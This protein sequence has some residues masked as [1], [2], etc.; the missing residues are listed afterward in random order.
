MKSREQ[1]EQ[2]LRFA[3]L[4]LPEELRSPK[5]GVKTSE[6]DGKNGQPSPDDD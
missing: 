5:G 2:N 6:N 3:E 1:L 4:E